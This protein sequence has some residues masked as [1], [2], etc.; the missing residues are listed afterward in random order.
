MSMTENDPPQTPGDMATDYLYPK[1]AGLIKELGLKQAAIATAIGIDQ[2]MISVGVTKQIGLDVHWVSIT[3]YLASKHRISPTWFLLGRGPKYLGDDAA[4]PG[5]ASGQHAAVREPSGNHPPTGLAAIREV[6]VVNAQNK[7]VAFE[8]GKTRRCA[9]RECV[10]VQTDDM[11][12]VIRPGQWVMLADPERLP[13]DGEIVLI[14][15]RQYT[16]VRRYRTVFDVD[17]ILLEAVNNDPHIHTVYVKRTD[18]ESIRVVLGV[19]FE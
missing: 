18:I 10:Q 3:E 17:A 2:S 12:P 7:F 19:V 9:A 6:G 11:S 15:T 16:W 5:S 8:G 4:T 14:M 13:H 1:L